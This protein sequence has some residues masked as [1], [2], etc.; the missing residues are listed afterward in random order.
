VGLFVVEGSS[1]GEV[2]EETVNEAVY[3]MFLYTPSRYKHT[4]TSFLSFP[5][6]A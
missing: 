4:T 5:P 2:N 1:V 3:A 6:S